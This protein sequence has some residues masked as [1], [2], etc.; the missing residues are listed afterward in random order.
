MEHVHQGRV[1]QDDNLFVSKRA[2]VE[3]RACERLHTTPHLKL[4]RAW[5]MDSLADVTEGF[6]SA[7]V[8]AVAC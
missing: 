2:W 5:S 1:D 4:P 6:W 7:E 3:D 8:A